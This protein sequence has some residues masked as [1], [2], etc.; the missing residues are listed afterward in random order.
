MSYYEK[1]RR[2]RRQVSVCLALTF[3]EWA[4]RTL[5]AVTGKGLLGS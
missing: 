1:I 3:A 5:S 2:K 4:S